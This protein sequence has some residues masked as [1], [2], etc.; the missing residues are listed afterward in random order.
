MYQNHFWEQ[1]EKTSREKSGEGFSQFIDTLNSNIQELI[2]SRESN[3][4]I[5][6]IIAIGLFTFY[7]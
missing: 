2:A 5:G 1:V 6:A 4:R 3:E 7:F